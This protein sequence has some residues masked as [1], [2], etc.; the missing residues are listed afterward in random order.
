VWPHDNAL[1]AAGLARYGFRDA[2]ATILRGLFEASRFIDLH[3]LP[4]LFCGFARRPGE[5]PTLY[6]VA[7]S[8]QSWAVGAVFF[9]VQ[10]CLGLSIRARERQ[11]RFTRPVLPEALRE[12]QLLGLTVGDATADVVLRRHPHDVG[13]DVLQRKGDVEIVVVK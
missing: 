3:R 12:V 4:E 5:G 6:P 9:L 10:A 7:C 11:I 8:P 1:V 2:A 13:V